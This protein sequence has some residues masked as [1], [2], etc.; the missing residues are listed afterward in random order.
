MWNSRFCGERVLSIALKLLT[1]PPLEQH[2]VNRWARSSRRGGRFIIPI[3]RRCRSAGWAKNFW[4]TLV[5]ERENPRAYRQEYLGIPAGLGDN[6][7]D[8]IAAEP[9]DDGKIRRFDRILAGVDWGFYPDPWA[10]NRVYYDSARRTL[11]VFCELTCYKAVNRQTAQKIKELGVG[12]REQITADSAEPKSV[13]D[14]R[15]GGFSAVVR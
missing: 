7:F 15:G 11:Y 9:I 2:W 8:N 1:R 12:P 5:F 3:T 14:Y 13:E 4:T 10:F 6:I